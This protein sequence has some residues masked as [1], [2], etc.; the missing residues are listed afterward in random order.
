MIK[1]ITIPRSNHSTP[2]VIYIG[3]ALS[4]LPQL[5]GTRRAIVIT[6]QNI[7]DLWGTSVEKYEK[8]V[9]RG[10]E[11]NKNIGTYQYIQRQRLSLGADRHTVLIGLGGGII[12]DITGFVA[13]TY[14]RGVDFGFVATTLLSQVDASVGG[15]NGVNLE[16]YKNILGTFNQPSWVICD[17]TV[18]ST[19]PLR[20]LR[21][22]YAEALKCGLL[23]DKELFEMFEKGDFQVEKIVEHS[24]NIKAAIVAR[25]EQESG[26][27]KQLNLGH[28]FA[29]AIEKCS[30]G[31]YLHGEAV[32]IGLVMAAQKSMGQGLL[33]AEDYQ[34]I[35]N[36]LKRLGLPTE[37]PELSTEELY[38]VMQ[39]D[40]KNQDG[41][42][43]FV[44]LGG[45]G[46]LKI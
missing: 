22:G 14:M 44:L 7:V 6:E 35:Y 42:I 18:L 24:V 15:K 12:T 26:L 27:R 41:Q 43:A 45:I 23:A 4:L 20:E 30:V 31:A 5:V 21:A 10:G 28:T 11:K 29:H 19:L 25:D 1:E 40:K 8:I 16:G 3:Q 36:T 32:A 13:S 38:K 2:S 33:S 9:V 39:S 46:E 17:S 34:R 37:C